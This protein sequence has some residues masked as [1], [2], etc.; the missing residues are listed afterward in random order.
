MMRFL[1]SISELISSATS[2][3]DQR[4]VDDVTRAGLSTKIF[5]TIRYERNLFQ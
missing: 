5:L 3:N 2:E 4:S 1:N